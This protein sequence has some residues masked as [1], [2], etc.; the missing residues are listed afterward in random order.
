MSA[1]TS[2]SSARRSVIDR[3]LPPRPPLLTRLHRLTRTRFGRRASTSAP[4]CWSSS[5]NKRRPRKPSRSIGRPRTEPVAA[6]MSRPVAERLSWSKRR[7]PRYERSWSCKNTRTRQHAM[8][9][10]MIAV[11]D[12]L[13]VLCL[14]CCQSDQRSA[15]GSVGQEQTIQ[16]RHQRCVD[17]SHRGECIVGQPAKMQQVQRNTILRGQD[18]HS[19]SAQSQPLRMDEAADCAC[20]CSCVWFDCVVRRARITAMAASI[21]SPSACCG[22]ISRQTESTEACGKGKASACRNEA[23]RVV[24]FFAID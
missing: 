16:E 4:S 5:A 2:E 11:T 20:A 22:A 19:N 13:C 3:L 9:A 12:F 21:Q 17:R 24:F 18:T 1:E 10:A 7:K 15:A 6:C 14:L 8:L 23:P